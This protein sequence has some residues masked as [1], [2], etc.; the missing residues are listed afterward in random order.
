ML[1]NIAETVRESVKSQI[2]QRRTSNVVDD[3]ITD[4]FMEIAFET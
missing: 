2:V 3:K 1:Q 4:H